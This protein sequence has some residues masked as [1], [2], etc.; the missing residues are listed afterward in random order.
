MLPDHGRDEVGRNLWRLSGPS[1][2]L[3]LGAVFPSSPS[4]R[5]Q[6]GNF[7]F[8]SCGRIGDVWN[9][10]R[11]PYVLTFAMRWMPNAH[12]HT[13]QALPVSLYAYARSCNG[14]MGNRA[15]LHSPSLSG[16]QFEL[17]EL[18][19][20]NLRHTIFLQPLP[21]EALMTSRPEG[22]TP[23]REG[24]VALFQV[25]TFP[26]V[27]GLG[28]ERLRD[29]SIPLLLLGGDLCKWFF[30]AVWLHCFSVVLFFAKEVG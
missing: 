27:L 25:S 10:S 4:R 18:S 23:G 17:H 1:P 29:S 3:T 16:P 11:S 13:R 20:V 15:F 21:L 28:R 12:L 9:I 7:H 26:K 24:F 2:H 30:K 6:K 8:A 22:Q 5:H 14:L 19:E